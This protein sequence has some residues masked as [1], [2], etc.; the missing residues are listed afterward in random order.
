MRA[1]VFQGVGQKL[2]IEDRQRPTAGPGELVLRVAYC[3]ICGS[4]IHGTEPSP[5]VL[6]PGVVLGHEFSGEVVESGSP[7]WQPGDRVIGVPLHECEECRPLGECRDRLGI[8]CGRGKIVGLAPDVPGGYAEFVRLGARHALRVPDGVDLRAAALAEPL[9]V[10]AHAVRMAGAVL[11]ARVLVLGA[12]PI[13]L[14]VTQFALAAGAAAVVVSEPDPTRRQRAVAL[15]ATAAL[16]PSAGDI[17]AAVA[18]QAGGPPE[19]VFECVGAPGLIRQCMDLVAVRGRVV[20]VGVY[21]H[22]D[23]IMPRIGIRKEVAVQ[24]VL[25]YV[26]EDFRLVLDMLRG[27]RIQAAPLI[28]AVIGL[29]EVPEMFE[30]LRRPNPHAKVLIDPGLSSPGT[31][32]GS[33]P[34]GR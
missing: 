5:F 2:V 30:L 22:E 23:T 7:D 11:G 15:G 32:P 34:A 21:R 26:A 18:T 13:G 6:P 9:A 16:D 20:V 28:T 4:D 17:G 33:I 14:G 24:F 3:G 1:A 10:G 31:T 25:G 12:G 29:D 27:G 19:I 8:L